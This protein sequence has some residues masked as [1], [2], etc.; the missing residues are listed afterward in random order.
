MSAKLGNSDVAATK[1]FIRREGQAG[2]STLLLARIVASVSTSRGI[3]VDRH[4]G[5]NIPHPGANALRYK[6]FRNG[7]ATPL[8]ASRVKEKLLLLGAGK[9]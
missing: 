6:F 2:S 3:A 7:T 1:S 8:I 4:H 5:I 9:V